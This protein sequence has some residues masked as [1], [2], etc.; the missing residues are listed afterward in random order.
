MSLTSYMV[1]LGWVAIRALCIWASCHCISIIAPNVHTLHLHNNADI[2]AGTFAIKALSN[3]WFDM[4]S[5]QRGTRIFHE[6]N[7]TFPNTYLSVQHRVVIWL[8]SSLEIW[9]RSDQAQH[10]FIELVL[11][12]NAVRWTGMIQ[13]RLQSADAQPCHDFSINKTLNISPAV[14]CN[15]S[16]RI[17]LY[18][19]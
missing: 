16:N 10:S 14:N 2:Y 4:D 15:L 7:D 12:Y 19:N 17:V 9:W 5:S 11:L 13:F 1:V 8:L 3:V 18:V 6:Q